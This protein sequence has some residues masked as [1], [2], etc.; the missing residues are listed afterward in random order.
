[1]QKYHEN[2]SNN[3]ERS[4]EDTPDTAA[5][6]VLT[7][8]LEYL[9]KALTIQH[10]DGL[11][12]LAQAFLK[13]GDNEI[14]DQ[15]V[16]ES[17]NVVIFSRRNEDNQGSTTTKNQLPKKR[18]VG[19]SQD[20]TNHKAR[21]N[22][23]ASYQNGDLATS[24]TKDIDPT[25]DNIPELVTTLSKA[26]GKEV[27]LAWS[28][29]LEKKPWMRWAMSFAPFLPAT[30]P[31]RVNF[32]LKL[33]QFF[34]LHGQALWERYFWLP[35]S[36]TWAPFER[37]QNAQKAFGLLVYELY[38][39]EG[40]PVFLFLDHYPHPSWPVLFE[41]A[42][43]VLNFRPANLLLYLN[44]QHDKRWPSWKGYWTPKS[45]S[46]GSQLANLA[47][48]PWAFLEWAAAR[49]KA[50][51]LKDQWTF[52]KSKPNFFQQLKAAIHANSFDSTRCPYIGAVLPEGLPSHWRF[53]KA[54]QTKLQWDYR[55]QRAVENEC[56]V[57]NL[58]LFD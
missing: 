39:L 47:N 7:Q 18:H 19:A 48:Q 54:P 55:R 36:L 50:A 14:L 10:A 1:M 58:I 31:G 40:L 21:L 53:P 32:N 25:K 52:L 17:L 45:S 37:L 6:D 57:P 29:I 44:D 16:N 11:T 9:S 26:L 41:D 8:F 22:H 46:S 13:G 24:E 34:C 4:S 35:I 51:C 15:F 2:S 12:L 43:S 3:A 23:C 20:V 5:P 42:L 30:S 27:A 33:Q 28:F 56:T 49:D 38:T